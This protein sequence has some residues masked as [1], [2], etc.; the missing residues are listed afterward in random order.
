MMG[1]NRFELQSWSTV[2]SEL[3]SCSPLRGAVIGSV[4]ALVLGACSK[5]PSASVEAASEPSASAVEA[6]AAEPAVPASAEAAAVAGPARVGAPAPDFTLTDLDGKSVSLSQYRGKVVVL[7]WFNPGCPFVRNAHTAGSLK[8]LA[9]KHAGSGVVWLAINSGGAGKQGA[10]VDANRE[11]VTQFGMQHPVLIDETGKV[12]QLY[13][14]E[15][16]P[17]MYVVNPEGVLVYKGAI[18]NSPDGEGQSPEGG[19]LVNYVDGA[20]SAVRSGAKVS[21]EETKAYGCSVK[22]QNL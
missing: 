7:E 10:G 14:A 2:T 16:T 4:L 11:G 9:E 8:G 22:Y 1:R 12:G 15:R 21:P 5:P 20:I 19:K 18:D 6:K 17:H 13:G 3:R